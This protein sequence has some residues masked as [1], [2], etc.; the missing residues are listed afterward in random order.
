MLTIWL[1]DQNV[2]HT[3]VGIKNLFARICSN[4][5][6]FVHTHEFPTH[7]IQSNSYCPHFSFLFILLLWNISVVI[8]SFF[9]TIKSLLSIL[10][11]IIFFIFHIFF[12][13]SKCILMYLFSFIFGFFFIIPPWGNWLNPKLYLCLRLVPRC[14]TTTPLAWKILIYAS[15]K[16]WS[17]SWTIR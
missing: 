17:I 4:L 11:L 1:K 14:E 12:I 5:L 13:S 3:Y 9:Y 2:D 16:S 10:C 15:S 6:I 8:L 7:K